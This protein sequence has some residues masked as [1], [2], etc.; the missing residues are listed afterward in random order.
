MY[1]KSIMC[2][3]ASTLVPRF[4]S[5]FPTALKLARACLTSWAATAFEAARSCSPMRSALGCKMKTANTSPKSMPARMRIIPPA[6]KSR[7]ALNSRKSWL[8]DACASKTCTACSAIAL[9]PRLFFLLVSKRRHY[10]SGEQ[11]LD[12]DAL[13]VLESAEVRDYGELSDAAFSHQVLDLA[14][15]FLRRA[16][17]SDLLINNFVVSELGQRFESAA[18]IES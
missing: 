10:A 7:S 5:I 18:R 2:A 11:M 1:P 6:T 17:E 15:N 14:N 8:P 4:S 16:N 3:W 12:L 9:N 13:P